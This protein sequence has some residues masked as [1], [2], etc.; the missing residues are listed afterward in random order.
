ML[1]P[2][3]FQNPE[4]LSTLSLDDL[5]GNQEA[6]SCSNQR[7]FNGTGGIGDRLNS[8]NLYT[9]LRTVHCF[10][11][12]KWLKPAKGISHR[13]RVS[14]WK[15][16]DCQRKQKMAKARFLIT[17]QLLYQLSYTGVLLRKMGPNPEVSACVSRSFSMVGL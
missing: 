12:Q 11:S 14:G 1:E 10:Y 15:R 8:K 7:N 13:I 9:P 4:R 2:V 17:N 16:R 5:E 3:A 6:S